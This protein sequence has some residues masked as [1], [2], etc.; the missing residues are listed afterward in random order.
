MLYENGSWSGVSGMLQRGKLIYP[1]Y[2]HP[3][4][5]N[6]CP[7]WTFSTPLIT[8][9]KRLFA[10]DIPTPLPRYTQFC[11]CPFNLTFGWPYSCSCYSLSCLPCHILS[12]KQSFTDFFINLLNCKKIPNEKMASLR[13]RILFGSWL[14]Y[15][16]L[17]RFVYT[18][19]VLS[20]LAVQ[21]I[22]KRNPEHPGIGRKQ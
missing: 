21:P 19:I 1:L 7:F 16:T 17:V 18:S 20:F 5:K 15:Q 9:S 11:C 6:D 2:T 4:S 14:V 13:H 12:G 10:T 22:P 8:P 3:S